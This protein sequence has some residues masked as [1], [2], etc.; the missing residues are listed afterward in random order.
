[1]VSKMNQKDYKAIARIMKESNVLNINKK[2]IS[3]VSQRLADY[4]EK[5]KGYYDHIK[6]KSVKGFNRQQFLKE[7]G[8]E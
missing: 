5:D 4:F 8:V 3:M 6:Q 7:C 2:T 1:M